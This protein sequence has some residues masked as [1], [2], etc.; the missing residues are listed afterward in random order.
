MSRFSERLVWL[1]LLIV[2][3][4]CQGPTATE[5]ASATA[6]AQGEETPAQ[7]AVS[8]E[9]AAATDDEDTDY[10]QYLALGRLDA[11]RGLLEKAETATPGYV[12]FNPYKSATTYLIDKDGLVVHTWT[13]ELA[14]SG[15]M[16]L[17]DNGRLF[18]TAVDTQAPVIGGGGQGGVFQ[19]FAWDGEMSWEYYFN[20]E[21]YRPHHDV[22]LMPNGNFLAIA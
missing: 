14:I 12:L 17:K 19:E 20:S 16:Y 15:G 11:K 7:D 9:E 2:L 18:R 5:D 1:A 10:Q 6:N 13:S 4:A 22:V 3:G 8:A 21:D